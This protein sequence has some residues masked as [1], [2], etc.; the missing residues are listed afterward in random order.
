[1]SK[2]AAI[3]LAAG[4]SRRFGDA[5]KLLAEIAGR[6]LIAH[7]VSAFVASRATDIV[8]VTG[9]D[10]LA[11]QSALHGLPVWFTH[12]PDHLSGMGGSIATGLAAI[13]PDC[14]GVLICPGD[15]P[16]VTSQFIDTL[17]DAFAASGADRIIRATLPDGRPAHPVL[18]PARHF[19]AL[20]QLSGPEGGRDLLK[21]LA[22]DIVTLNST[23]GDTALDI[24]TQRDLEI[25]RE[26]LRNQHSS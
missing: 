13:P 1:M 7:S 22:A 10:Q 16:G 4:S 18:W 11:I 3:V 6:P 20:K 2:I 21:T 9:P 23:D 17:I 15:M 14:D 12:N 8:V 19:P 25:L 26:R 5:N 24:D